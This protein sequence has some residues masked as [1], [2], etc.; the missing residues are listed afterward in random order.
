MAQ[1]ENVSIEKVKQAIELLKKKIETEATDAKTM[2]ER[3]DAINR[4]SERL[5]QMNAEVAKL[6]QPIADRLKVDDLGTLSETEIRQGIEAAKQLIQTYKSGGD[7]ANQLAERIVKA[8]KHLKD[9]GIEAARTAQSIQLMQDQLDK[10][11][12]LTESAL[13]AQVQYWQR[14]ADDP[15]T[16]A[17]SVDLYKQ[18]IE[19]AKQLLDSMASAK[20]KGVT[21]PP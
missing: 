4:L 6:S 9:T 15:K 3:G 16:A 5:T 14:L 19:K 2:Q 20:V 8:E 7:E 12:V 10:G 21:L 17:E 1:S 13:K 11:D 18:N